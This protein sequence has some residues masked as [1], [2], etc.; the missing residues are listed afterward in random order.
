MLRVEMNQHGKVSWL[1]WYSTVCRL[2]ILVDTCQ[3]LA[4]KQ[5][6]QSDRQL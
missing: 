2:S 6:K 4:Y 1:A 5:S 3:Y